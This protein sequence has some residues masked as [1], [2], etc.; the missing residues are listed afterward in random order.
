[1]AAF[2][3]I[4]PSQYRLTRTPFS[5]RCEGFFFISRTTIEDCLEFICISFEVFFGASLEA[6]IPYAFVNIMG[7]TESLD[8]TQIGFYVIITRSGMGPT[9][10]RTYQNG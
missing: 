6:L 8:I 2:Y 1:M 5:S 10:L 9:D 3:A 4:D 7:S